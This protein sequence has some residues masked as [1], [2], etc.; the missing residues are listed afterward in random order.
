MNYTEPRR[1]EV[2]K[3]LRR[4]FV[5]NL[6]RNTTPAVVNVLT[7]LV[8][9]FENETLYSKEE[10]AKVQ[11]LLLEVQYGELQVEDFDNKLEE[12][13]VEK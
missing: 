13:E 10:S 11:A 4:F 5:R 2:K 1:K 6:E 7:E 8:G 12:M 9:R 3:I